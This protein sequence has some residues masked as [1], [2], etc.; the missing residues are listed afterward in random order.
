M[1]SAYPILLRWSWECVLYLIIIIKLEVWII[2]HCL[3]LGHET[4]VCAVCLT[5][6]LRGRILGNE[7]PSS[8]GTW[9]LGSLGVKTDLNCRFKRVAFIL[10][11]MCKAPPSLMRVI[12]TLSCFRNVTY[13]QKG[14]EAC[15]FRPLEEDL[16]IYNSSALYELYAG[17]HFWHFYIRANPCSYG[18]ALLC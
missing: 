10:A 5:M 6:F 9:L 13:R 17:F 18:N 7:G 2:N 4:M 12:P 1:S 15:S 8:L 3:G 14:L 16:F 11:L